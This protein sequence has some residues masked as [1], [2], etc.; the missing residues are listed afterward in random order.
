MWCPWHNY[1]SCFYLKFWYFVYH[2]VFALIFIFK[3]L[4]S[5]IIPLGYSVF[6]CLTCLTLIR[7][8][9]RKMRHALLPSGNPSR[10]YH[11]I[12]LTELM[13]V[14]CDIA[15]FTWPSERFE[16]GNGYLVLLTQQ[17][18]PFSEDSNLTLFGEP[19]P[20]HLRSWLQSISWRW[21]CD[22]ALPIRAS[23][24]LAIWLVQE[25]SCESVTTNET[26]FWGFG[27]NLGEG[28]LLLFYGS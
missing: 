23:Y 20:P 10:F 14:Y 8:F 25:W 9:G 13:F 22:S 1:S 5:S 2:R 21:A 3:I 7:S 18:S 6:L 12:C 11:R 26:Q 28:K 16:I 4:H 17:H 24:P 15:L 19:F 27:M